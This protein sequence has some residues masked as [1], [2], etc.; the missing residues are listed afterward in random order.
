MFRKMPGADHT[1]SAHWARQRLRQSIAL[2][3]RQRYGVA[4]PLEEADVR[5]A[6]ARVRE[7]PVLSAALPHEPGAIPGRVIDSAPTAA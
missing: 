6:R 3:L 2:Y 1:L 4:M 7:T 5:L